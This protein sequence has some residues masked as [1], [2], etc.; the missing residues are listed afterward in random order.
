RLSLCVWSRDPRHYHT[1]PGGDPRRWSRRTLRASGGRTSAEPG[2]DSSEAA[3]LEGGGAS[4]APG[5][6]QNPSASGAAGGALG[7]I[8]PDRP[9]EPLGERRP[10]VESELPGG[11]RRVQG[12][13]RLPVRPTRVPDQAPPEPDQPRDL[14]RQLLDRDLEAGAEIHGVGL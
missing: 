14:L 13:A 7:A 4:P 10:G 8:P 1:T 12:S 11:P 3:G 9:L 6:V 5:S 2:K